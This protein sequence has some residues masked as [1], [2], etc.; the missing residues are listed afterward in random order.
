MAI[1]T[2]GSG[3]NTN[4]QNRPSNEEQALSVDAQINARIEEAMKKEIAYKAWDAVHFLHGWWFTD[5][6]KT[7]TL[8]ITRA[9]QSVTITHLGR[10]VFQG[11]K[12]SYPNLIHAY[13]PGPWEAELE[14]LYQKAC[15]LEKTNNDAQVKAGVARM[16]KRQEERRKNFGF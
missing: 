7:K 5:R 2:E 13:L 15:A 12:G 9:Y 11:E 8:T 3:R 16:K 10:K 6:I 4:E 1:I 14:A